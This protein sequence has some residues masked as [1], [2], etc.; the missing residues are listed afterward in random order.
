MKLTFLNKNISCDIQQQCYGNIEHENLEIN[1][2]FEICNG[3]KVHV[4][5]IIKEKYRLEYILHVDFKKEKTI[6]FNNEKEYL[7]SLRNTSDKIIS[8]GKCNDV[9]CGNYYIT[10]YYDFEKNILKGLR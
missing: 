1:D 5:D 9:Y 7:N 8:N 4:I 3:Y 10:L 6:Y 2:I